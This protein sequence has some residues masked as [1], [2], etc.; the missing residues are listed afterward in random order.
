[1]PVECMLVEVLQDCQGLG[2]VGGTYFHTHL[3]RVS[4]MRFDEDG[5]VLVDSERFV[6]RVASI[7]ATCH[8]TQA[9][10]FGIHHPRRMRAPLSHPVMCVWPLNS[11][12]QYPELFFNSQ[13]RDRH[14][15]AAIS[16]S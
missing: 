13:L 6:K 15:D 3:H 11:Q 4:G 10:Q 14:G 16:F 12:I 7:Y 8:K 1:M 2:C 5:R 9:S